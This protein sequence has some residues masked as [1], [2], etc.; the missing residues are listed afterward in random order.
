MKNKI[1]SVPEGNVKRSLLI[2]GSIS[3]L[4]LLFI[5]SLSGQLRILHFGEAAK[6]N[7]TNFFISRIL[8]WICLLLLWLYAVKIERQKLLIWPEKKYKVSTYLLS[9]FLI[10]AVLFAGGL[11]ISIILSL[12]G[13]NKSSEQM[14]EIVIILSENKLLLFFTVITAG[15][16]EELIFRGYLLPRLEIIF[17]KPYW[18]ITISSLFFGLLHYR[19]GT[20]LNVVGPVFIGFVFA[21]YYWRYRNIKVIIVCHILWDLIAISVSIAAKSHELHNHVKATFF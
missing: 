21:Y 1:K 2:V 8:Y 9:G 17:K 18:A 6:L 3:I 11:I 13:F 15:I 19:Y 4:L 12:S 16:V 10:F 14:S 5:I 20:V 7:G